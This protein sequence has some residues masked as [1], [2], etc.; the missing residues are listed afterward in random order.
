MK[1]KNKEYEEE[2]EEEINENEEDD[3][4]NT[5]DNS[6]EIG[7]Q[8]H[9]QSDVITKN[10]PHLPKD[11]KYS[12]FANIDVAN[13]FLR[14]RTYQL[15]TYVNK[16]EYIS[17]KE[18]ELMKIERKKIYDITTPLQFKEYL[19][20]I[21]KIYIWH[22]F[23]QLKPEIAEEYFKILIEQLKQAKDDGIIDAMYKDR[24]IFNTAF[25]NYEEIRTHAVNVDDFGLMNN[26]MTQSEV[27]KA[28]GG[29]GMNSM[30][31][32]INVTRDENPVKEAEEEPE[33]S[34]NKNFMSKFKK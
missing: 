4:D 12:K 26:M 17:K 11:T 10:F 6:L 20:K 2:F 13:Y 23:I 22:N 34:E 21:G 5:I 29:W 16:C 32:T 33:N 15:W 8:I 1:K 3:L 19:E 27:K 24:I 18:L 25:A 9:T 14:S 31:T 7:G 28:H 30:N